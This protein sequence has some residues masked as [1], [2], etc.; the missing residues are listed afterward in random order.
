MKVTDLMIKITAD[1]ATF[2]AATASATRASQQ[3]ADR[4]S[5]NMRKVGAALSA[6]VTVPLTLMAK[7]ALQAADIQAKA[8]AKV[9]QALMQTGNAAG[10]TLDQLKKMSTELQRTTLYGDEEVLGGVTAKLL[11]FTSIAGENFSRLQKLVLDFSTQM[12]QD[13]SSA[14]ITLGKALD[15]P[16]RALSQLTRLGITFTAEEQKK[17]KAM[18]E[19]GRVAEA[20]SL[21]LDKLNS[22]YG[23]QAEAA[24]KTGAGAIQQMR[25][26]WGDLIETIGTTLMP[27]LVAL[28]NRLKALFERLQNLSPATRKVIV[29]IGALAASL[30]PLLLTLGSLNLILPAI[31]SGITAI[32]GA[33]PALRTAITALASPLGVILA[34][35]VGIGVAYAGLAAKRNQW[36]DDFS[37]EVS[38]MDDASLQKEKAELLEAIDAYKKEKDVRSQSLKNTAQAQ[39]LAYASAAGPGD[40][41]GGSYAGLM[42]DEVTESQKITTAS[43]KT[44]SQADMDRAQQKLAIIAAEEK[45]RAEESS[46]VEQERKAIMDQVNGSI[47]ETLDLLDEETTV[48]ERLGG[49]LG[50]LQEQVQALE[51]KKLLPGTTVEE[52]AEYNDEINILQSRIDRLSK[53]TNADLTAMATPIAKVT[54]SFSKMA[55]AVRGVGNAMA[56]VFQ[57][58]KNQK[59]RSDWMVEMIQGGSSPEE[60]SSKINDWM[61]RYRNAFGNNVDALRDFVEKK[62]QEWN[63]T[64]E[65]FVESTIVGLF[66]IMG[67]SIVSGNLFGNLFSFISNQLGNLLISLGSILITTSEAMAA[68]K[69]SLKALFSNPFAGIIAGA[70]MIIAGGALI[71]L[72]NKKAQKATSTVALAQGG[73]AYGP[74]LAMVGDNMNAASDPEVIAPLSKLRDYTGGGQQIQLQISGEFRTKG[75]DLVATLSNESARYRTMGIS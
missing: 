31:K 68:F 47:E 63:T 26:A 4:I 41:I 29:V 1:A 73:L 37:K 55:V 60:A 6:A 52:I 70:A 7:S 15:N 14:A 62:I 50:S 61:Q 45:R 11:S 49:V 21:I 51:K 75:R 44:Y 48:T 5:K 20:Q 35:I 8:E 66:E 53:I 13:A 34:L 30:G 46:K 43:G 17:I 42:A 27:Y 23:G 9:Q 33:L 2:K 25:M 56:P 74:T 32:T 69:E 67:K 58:D 64:I 3:M 16:V 10:F 18:A 40:Y 28:A 54:D 24:A 59:A 38:S 72:A 71:A 19:T 39:R 57:T 12:G 22:K 36:K 65:R